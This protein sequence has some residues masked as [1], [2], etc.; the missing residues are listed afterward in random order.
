MEV[1]AEEK[2]QHTVQGIPR[3]KAD[4]FI[5]AFTQDDICKKHDKGRHKTV[6]AKMLQ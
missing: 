2:G 6:Y 4:L 5:V 3:V 1:K